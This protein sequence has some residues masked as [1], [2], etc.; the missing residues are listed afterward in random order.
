MSTAGISSIGVLFPLIVFL[1][2]LAGPSISGLL[3]HLPDLP[4]SLSISLQGDTFIIIYI[5]CLLFFDS[6]CE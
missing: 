4:S 6:Y 1:S 2:C 3:L 5:T